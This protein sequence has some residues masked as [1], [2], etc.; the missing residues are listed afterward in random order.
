[1]TEEEKTKRKEEIEK[2]IEHCLGWIELEKSFNEN[3][4][5]L[6]FWYYQLHYYKEELRKLEEEE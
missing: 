5:E 2:E 6:G 4:E 1:M 3:S